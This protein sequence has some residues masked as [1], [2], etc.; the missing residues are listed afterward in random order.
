MGFK[1]TS[2]EYLYILNNDTTINDKTIPVLEKALKEY[3]GKQQG[4]LSNQW[5]LTP[6]TIFGYFHL[7]GIG[8]LGLWFNYS[9]DSLI[10]FVYLVFRIVNSLLLTGTIAYLLFVVQS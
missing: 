10:A 9:I 6:K 1:N 8:L 7:S 3:T 4:K 5:K 2:C